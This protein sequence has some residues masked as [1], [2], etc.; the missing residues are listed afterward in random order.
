MKKVIKS[1]IAKIGAFVAYFYSYDI[2]SRL[3]KVY[4]MAYSKWICKSIGT[5]EGNVTIC[6]HCSLHGGE[7]IHM[8]NGSSIGRHANIET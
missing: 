4:D 5:I 1:N 6:S 7:N 2:Y 3:C 8:K